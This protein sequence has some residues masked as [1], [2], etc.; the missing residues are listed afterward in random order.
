MNEV[1]DV[2]YVKSEDGMTKI[3]GLTHSDYVVYVYVDGSI[4]LVPYVK[5][6]K[7]LIERLDEA[8]TNFK[9]NIVSSPIF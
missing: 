7:S 2:Y 4:T 9:R 6:R 3:H 5:K 1:K 8:R